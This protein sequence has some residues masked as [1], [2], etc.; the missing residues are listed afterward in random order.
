M[1]WDKYNQ[2]SIKSITETYS[3]ERSISFVQNIANYINKEVYQKKRWP[4]LMRTNINLQINQ[5]QKINI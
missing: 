2:N 4:A 5:I 3:C 1:N